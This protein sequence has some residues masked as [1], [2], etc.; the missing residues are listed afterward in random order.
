MAKQAKSFRL[1]EKTVKEIESMS[2]RWQI[3]QAEVI[4]LLVHASE[5]IGWEDDEKFDEMIELARRI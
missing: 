2:K 4:A 5:A 3:G 1:S